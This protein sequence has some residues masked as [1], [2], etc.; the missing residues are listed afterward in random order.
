MSMQYNTMI[1]GNGHVDLGFEMIED[2]AD[3]LNITLSLLCICSCISHDVHIVIIH[4]FKLFLAICL[5]KGIE[6]VK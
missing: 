5:Y 1:I 4:T 6:E 2:T 3:D